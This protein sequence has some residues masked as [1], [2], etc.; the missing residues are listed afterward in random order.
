MRPFPFVGRRR[1]CPSVSIGRSS[2]STWLSCLRIVN[3][4]Y[5]QRPRIGLFL[6]GHAG[7]V[8]GAELLV[9]DR[10]ARGRDGWLFFGIT[11]GLCV[12]GKEWVAAFSGA[13]PVLHTCLYSR[14]DLGA[15][16]HG[17]K[18]QREKHKSSVSVKTLFV[19]YLCVGC[20][21]VKSVSCCACVCMCARVFLSVGCRN[22]QFISFSFFFF[23]CYC[24]TP[25]FNCSRLPC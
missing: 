19:R 8:R 14:I 12:R 2:L 5:T 24:D 11:H 18:M 22:T 20:I 21:W 9:K 7:F 15:L 6:G 3:A 1:A 4:M 23:F 13:Q 17:R 25:W 16:S 10:V